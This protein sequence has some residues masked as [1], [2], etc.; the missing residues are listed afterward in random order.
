MTERPAGGP[1]VAADDDDEL[2][3]HDSLVAQLTETNG[4]L[5][6]AAARARQSRLDFQHALGSHD[7]PAI[8]A[9]RFQYESDTA[10]YQEF[11]RSQERIMHRLEHLDAQRRAGAANRLAEAMVTWTKVL[12]AATVVLALATLALIWATLAA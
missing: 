3:D 10:V 8:D 11:V 9:A 4:L 7:R 1:P 2:W 12:A 5:N 6:E